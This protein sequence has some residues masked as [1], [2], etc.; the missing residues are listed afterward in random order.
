MDVTQEKLERI[1]AAADKL[2]DENGRKKAP[3]VDAVRRSSGVGMADA[4]AGMQQWRAKREDG[5]RVE[6]KVPDSFQ[7][8]ASK[9]IAALWQ[10]AEEQAGETYRAAKAT[11]DR[12][13]TELEEVNDQASQA[14][15]ALSEDLASVA[16]ERDQAKEALALSSAKIVELER[17][18][19]GLREELSQAK[20]W[21]R[22]QEARSKELD[23]LASEL[24]VEL[25]HAHKASAETKQQLSELRSALDNKSAQLAASAAEAE[26]LRDHL[27]TIKGDFQQFRADAKAEAKEAANTLA[28][29]R[30]EGE[31]RARELQNEVDAQRKIASDAR[32]E[33]ARIN[34]LLQ[35]ERSAK[36]KAAPGKQPAKPRNQ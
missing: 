16:A 18:A 7:A 3:S 6:I 36:S 1:F 23:R 9:I 31:Q 32:E 30:V 20:S 4:N 10:I 26:T 5:G 24:R 19:T 34:G 11:W 14:F 22:E 25:D 8:E 21:G 27:E 2:Y 29:V 35:G 17:S 28:A 33:C 12:E 13:R 15:D